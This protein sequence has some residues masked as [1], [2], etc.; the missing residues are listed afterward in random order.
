VTDATYVLGTHDEE[1]ARLGLQH[2]VWRSRARETWAAAG[3]ARGQTI[4]D[5][6]C[7][8]GYATLD[9]AE[10][11]G[12]TGRVIGIDRSRRFLDVLEHAARE[13]GLSQI[14]TLEIDLD[15]LALPAGSA[16]GIWC[17]W[18]AA[19]VQKPRVLMQR[20]A[21]ALKPGG[22]LAA[23]EYFDYG[24]WRCVPPLAELD[25]F[26]DLVVASWRDAGGEPNIALD[27]PA[28][29][30][31]MGFTIT[32]AR[33]IVEL[34]DPHQPL[35]AWCRAFVS[36]GLHRLVDLGVLADTRAREIRQAFEVCE[37]LPHTRMITP[38]VLEIVGRKG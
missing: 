33:P 32:T 19:F 18:V 17:R 2:R 29:L 25:E 10:I 14:E 7:G 34:V 15:S 28:W 31:E 24:T 16:D 23:H 8:P 1:I 5:L 30:E 37:Q 3:F 38:G 22:A 26:V 20:A 12:P 36:S 4:L 6:G 11:V 35:W 13:R 27:L 9:L 21:D